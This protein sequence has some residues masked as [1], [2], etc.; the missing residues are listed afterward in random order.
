MVLILWEKKRISGTVSQ[1]QVVLKADLNF[2]H[3]LDQNN[4]SP[5]N[6]DK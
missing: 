5:N 1:F 4:K 3:F 6:G 2:A